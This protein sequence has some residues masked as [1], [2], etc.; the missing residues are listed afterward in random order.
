MMKSTY[1]SQHG[2]TILEVLVVLLVLVMLTGLALPAITAT[3]CDKF[4]NVSIRNLQSLH[5]AHTLYALDWNDRQVTWAR[6]DLGA[7][8]GDVQAYNR[9][10]G[11]KDPFD[12]GCQPPVVAGVDCGGT[13][14]A[15]DFPQ[16]AWAVQPINFPGPPNQ[17]QSVA[18]LGSF[19][20]P[21]ARPFHEYVNGRFFDPTFYAPKD[22]P[23]FEQV[24]P[25]F[26]QDCEF[27]A[28]GADLVLSSSYVLSPAAMFHPSV[29]SLDPGTGLFW[30][31]PWEFA[32]GYES[33][34]VSQARY[35]DRKSRMIEHNWLQNPAEPCNPSFAG[36]VPY[37]FN[38]SSFS[39]P[40]T[41]FYDGHV[42]GLSPS[43]A[44]RSEHRVFA[45]TG[46]RLWTRDTPFGANGYFVENAYDFAQTSFHILTIDGI[47]GRDTLE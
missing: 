1:R 3:T 39:V 37:F 26:E 42:N 38:H 27:V 32:Q 11:C 4:K 9:A 7:F 5:F 18:G 24:L 41:L 44:I 28:E 16:G 31:A 12:P 43:E 35:P 25:L 40:M 45:Q 20:V 22:A 30:R 10:H 21:N 36:C 8:D 2:L 33:P 34:S 15:F 19:R 23:V 29:L 13:L 14:Q 47:L 6:D 17:S 46:N